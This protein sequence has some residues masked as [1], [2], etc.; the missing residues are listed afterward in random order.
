M[1]NRARMGL[2]VPTGLTTNDTNKALYSEL[3]KLESLHSVIG[4]ENESL[5]FPDVHHTF[6]FCQL[7]VT[8]PGKSRQTLYTYLCRRIPETKDER[9]MFVM[10]AAD[11]QL[12]NPNTNTSPIFRTKI[13]AQLT[14]KLYK[15]A[16]ILVQEADA[17]NPWNVSYSQGLFHSSSDADLFGKN[18]KEAMQAA[19]GTLVGNI[20]EVDGETYLPYY[21]GKMMFQFDHRYGTFEGAT[22]ANLNV[23]SLPQP[24]I[25]QKRDFEY[26]VL[27]RYWVRKENVDNS[28][29]DWNHGWLIGFRDFTSSIVERTGIFTV[30]PRVGL[31]DQ[32]GTIYAQPEQ[33]QAIPALVANLN[34]LV[35]DYVTRQKV[36]W[37][38]LKKYM[39]FQLPVLSPSSYHEADLQF[40]VNAS[41]E[42]TCTSSDLA[43][44]S[45]EMG[46]SGKLFEWNP[47]RRQRLRAEL[48]GY[49]AHLYGLTR[50]ELRY[51]LDP[52][53]VF[54][55]GFPSETFRVLK[56]REIKQYGEYRT[57]RLVLEAYDEFAKSDRFRDEMP[58]RVS[59]IEATPTTGKARSQS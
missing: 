41:L 28:L 16:P 23:G 1:N 49:Y 33:G 20:F 50:D 45:E 53:D 26:R 52:K 56:E 7:T 47:D 10:S 36:G 27:P 55:E 19:G 42:L 44:Y 8:A 30:L 29:G 46:G 5:I 32:F 48:D 17:R 9:R 59:A 25:A 22:Q 2:L 6:K 24:S 14:M 34:A 31:S 35:L 18:T 51:I 15:A 3:I 37:T 13:D 43:N 21:E 40:V 57:Q 12:V 58:R 11:V 4:Y 39:L 54:G 38:H